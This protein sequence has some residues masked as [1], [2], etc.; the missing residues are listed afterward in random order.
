MAGTLQ[1]FHQ[2]FLDEV[3]LHA[4][5][6]G[7]YKQIAF[8]EKFA[9]YLI[10]AGEFNTFDTH[11]HSTPGARVH[12]WAGDPQSDDGV[13]SL[14]YADWTESAEIETL[15]SSDVDSGFK[16]LKGF[17]CTS[18]GEK[19]RVAW[20]ESGP[21]Y[22]LADSIHE[23]AKRDEIKVVRLYLLSNRKL[24]NRIKDIFDEELDGIPIQHRVW[25][26]ERLRLLV[27]SGRERE[28]MEID[29]QDEFGVTL[30]C[31][32]AHVGK[33]DD[34]QAYL[35]VV[36]GNLLA[37]IYEHWGT[38][39]LEQ[40]VRCFLQ[41]RGKVNRG[42]RDTI[43]TS[44]S[45]FFAYNNGITATAE[46]IETITNENG[47]QIKRL[48]NLQIVNGGQ[49]TA[50]IFTAG[51]GK[52]PADL[53]QVFVQMKLSV[54]SPEKAQEIVPNI[55]RYANSQNAVNAA[56]FF[57]NHP[58]HV[59]MEK[60]SRKVMAPQSSETTHPTRWYYERARGQYQDFRSQTHP[61]A[62]RK[63]FD[64][65][66][67]RKQVF[68]KTDLA[69]FCNVW[70]EIPHIVSQGAQKNFA[71]FANYIGEEWKKREADFN[72]IYF[73]EVIAKAIVF[74]TVERLVSK[75]PWYEGGYRANVVAYAI[76]RFSIA[77][78][79]AK[80]KVDFDKIW[81]NQELS[82]SMQNSLMEI[83][84][85]MHEVL[86][87]PPE[88]IR[89][90]SEFAKK[91]VCWDFAQKKHVLLPDALRVELI[92]PGAARSRARDARDEKKFMNEVEAQ[93]F[94]LSLRDLDRNFW[95]KVRSH[96]VRN[97]LI[98]EKEKQI[99][100]RSILPMQRIPSPKQAQILMKVL[101]KVRE[102]GFSE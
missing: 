52:Q 32:P 13:L 102:G 70:R 24:S 79:E 31:L 2:Q 95:R 37:S 30:P 100:E 41:A 94:V 18:L 48:K 8:V 38:R 9:D 82:Q 92:T 81:Q 83:A 40:N 25:D 50:S 43:A 90:I 89:N 80:K 77:V 22:A 85:V 12:G 1:D 42:I 86:L 27:E 16:R 23:C 33:Q 5:S 61:G 26:V 63:A 58:F 84:K 49:T 45:M 67:P 19:W 60:A 4:G 47:L 56:D 72:D 71:N 39:L 15:G 66:W 28:E 55:S 99:I 73:N 68:T 69:K 74:K 93:S 36:P 11:Y 101:I 54:V 78:N 59:M 29:F 35:A 75:Q 65:Q 64:K 44:P 96:G 76:A 17:L 10:D 62:E 20:E 97:R 6:D 98:T 7:Q 21:G 87:S 14:I 3:A 91:Q 53:E 51:R 34:Y 88:G 46:E 57:S